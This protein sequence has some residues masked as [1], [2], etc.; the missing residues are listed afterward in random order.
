MRRPVF[1]L[2][3]E[4]QPRL[5]ALSADLSRR[6]GAD[7]RVAAVASAAAALAELAELAAAGAAVALVIADERLTGI[8]P[9]QVL[10]RAHELHPNARRVLLVDRGNWSAAHPAVA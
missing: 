5:D 9:L 3:A 2:A 4:D 10:G 1:V 8:S 7:Y 6:Y